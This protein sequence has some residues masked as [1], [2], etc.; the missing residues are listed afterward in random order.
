M[1]KGWVGPGAYVLQPLGLG[2][3]FLYSIL[4][5]EYFSLISVSRNCWA[6]D[7]RKI[8]YL[9]CSQKARRFLVTVCHSKV[10]NCT[11]LNLAPECP[12]GGMRS[13]KARMWNNGSRTSPA[14][15][16]VCIR[17]PWRRLE[18]KGHRLTSSFL[19][20]RVFDRRVCPGCTF[21]Y[22]A[23]KAMI[24]L[25]ASRIVNTYILTFKFTSSQLTP[26]PRSTL[27]GNGRL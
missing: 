15:T 8:L 13:E 11:M 9:E 26:L 22:Y 14:C 6:A 24:Q 27:S 17:Y 4:E 18:C 12:Q 23:N 16:E 5:R 19:E 3:R 7:I 1:V 10:A 20:D 21:S 2:S 25:C